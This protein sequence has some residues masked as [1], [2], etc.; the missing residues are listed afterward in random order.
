MVGTSVQRRKEGR[1]MAQVSGAGVSEGVAHS[2]GA[3]TQFV[4]LAWYTRYHHIQSRRM[5]RTFSF[6]LA[7]AT[8]PQC[9]RAYTCLINGIEKCSSVQ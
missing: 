4:D 2:L 1:G 5:L 7:V 9:V 3:K 8:S 6:H